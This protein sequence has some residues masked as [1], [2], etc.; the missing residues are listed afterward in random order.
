[1]IFFLIPHCLSYEIS[2][3]F[4]VFQFV[5]LLYMAIQLL[6]YNLK[7]VFSLHFNIGVTATEINFSEITPSKND[8][9]KID[10]R[11]VA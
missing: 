1:M 3:E 9:L 7:L 4:I 5:N 10:F 8:L 11:R 6:V 2:Y